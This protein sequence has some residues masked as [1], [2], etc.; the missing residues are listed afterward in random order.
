MLGVTNIFDQEGVAAKNFCFIQVGAWNILKDLIPDHI[1]FMRHKCINI[2]SFTFCSRFR[3]SPHQI[4]PNQVAIAPVWLCGF[5]WQRAQQFLCQSAYLHT[6]KKKFIA[7]FPVISIFV[8]FHI[9]LSL[10]PYL[11]VCLSVSGSLL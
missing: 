11:S 2:F 8:C 1:C 7:F 10:S 5:A 4:C 3:F 6:S 9:P